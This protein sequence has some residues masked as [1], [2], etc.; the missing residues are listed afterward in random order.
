MPTTKRRHQVT[1]TPEVAHALEIAERRWPGR[2]QSA[3]LAALAALGAETIEAQEAH[4][5]EARRDLLRAV[6][7][8]FDEAFPDGYLA[9]LRLDWPQ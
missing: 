3:L 8:R 7:G 5:A 1:E 6:H 2:S 4:R 9:E